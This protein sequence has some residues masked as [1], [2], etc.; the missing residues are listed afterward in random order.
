MKEKRREARKNV[1]K[2]LYS[3]EFLERYEIKEKGKDKYERQ[4]Y[5]GIVDKKDEIDNLIDNY[6]EGWRV[7]RLAILDRNILRIGIYEM[8]YLDP[9]TPPEVMINEA[10]ELAKTYGTE[11]SPKFINGILDRVW[12]EEGRRKN[13]VE[14]S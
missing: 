7:D 10:V 8:L 5:D 4:V 13:K 11:E 1:L 12:H 3:K 14:T 6:A 2:A 9:P